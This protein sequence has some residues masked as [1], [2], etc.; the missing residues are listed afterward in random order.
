MNALLQIQIRKPVLYVYLPKS[1]Y[2]VWDSAI[3]NLAIV[4]LDIGLQQ[5]RT[6]CN[7]HEIQT[8]NSKIRQVDYKLPSQYA[9]PTLRARVLKGCTEYGVIVPHS[10][11]IKKDIEC[12]FQ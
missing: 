4:W 9:M 3:R 6:D 7:V 10:S 11:A 12:P 8:R 5:V 2:F 1:I